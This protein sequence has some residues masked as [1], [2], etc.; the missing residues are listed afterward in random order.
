MI[1]LPVRTF[2]ASLAVI[3]VLS[4]MQADAR[5]RA[6]DSL[7]ARHAAAHN[8]PEALVRR[9]IARESKYNP[10]LIHA[11]NYG[12]M[13]IRLKTARFLGYRGDAQGLLDRDTNLAYAVKYLAGALHAAGGKHDRAVANYQRGYDPGTATRRKPPKFFATAS[14]RKM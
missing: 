9:V 2:V 14:A 10:R 12:L 13:Q 1:F 3:S 11:G 5:D 6:L 8:V 4:P 7:I